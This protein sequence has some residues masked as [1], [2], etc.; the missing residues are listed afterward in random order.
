MLG[1]C[2]TDLGIVLELGPIEHN[3]VLRQKHLGILPSLLLLRLHLLHLLL[4][5][6]LAHTS[7]LV[8][9]LHQLAC[10]LIEIVKLLPPSRIFLQILEVSQKVR[11]KTLHGFLSRNGICLFVLHPLDNLPSKLQMHSKVS[12]M[13]L[14]RINENLSPCLECIVL[15]RRNG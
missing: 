1:F 13:I 11:N 6:V 7:K 5:D 2:L 14:V 3:L 9:N 12:V 4:L 15:K 8:G 10:L